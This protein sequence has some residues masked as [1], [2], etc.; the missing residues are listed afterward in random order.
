MNYHVIQNFQQSE[1]G[2]MSYIGTNGQVA[3]VLT[4][5]SYTRQIL[6][7]LIHSWNS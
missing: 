6:V 7:F 4:K 2:H 1:L 5:G 3:D